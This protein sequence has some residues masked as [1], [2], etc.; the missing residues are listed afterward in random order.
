MLKVFLPAAAIGLS[1]TLVNL[2]SIFVI[3]YY[4]DESK[5]DAAVASFFLVLLVEF[6][7]SAFVQGVGVYYAQFLRR[8]ERDK[9][10]E[11]MR[12]GLAISFLVAAIF[13]AG[14]FTIGTQKL[15]SLVLLHSSRAAIFSG[16]QYLGLMMITFAFRPFNFLIYEILTINARTMFLLII[17]TLTSIINIVLAII[18]CSP[19]ILH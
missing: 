4:F 7:I 17:R 12:Y 11:L 2:I 9:I 14:F 8:N 15:V 10:F 19:H 3:S 1:I 13:I 18:F 16:G 6:T 5:I